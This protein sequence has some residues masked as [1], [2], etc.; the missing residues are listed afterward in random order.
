MIIGRFT[1]QP[2]EREAYA[3]EYEDDLAAGDSMVADPAPTITIAAQ[4]AAV[5]DPTP[6]ALAALDATG[7]RVTLWLG[8]GSNGQS[9]KISV[10]AATASGRILQDEFIVKIKDY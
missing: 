2:A 6:L 8:A 7:T 4:V 10:T 9:Y 1:K 5:P 3:I